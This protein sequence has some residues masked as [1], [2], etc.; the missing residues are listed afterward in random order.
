MKGSAASSDTAETIDTGEV[1]G[2][3]TFFQAVMNVLN[4]LTGVGLLSI[5]FAL[6]QAG[7]AG[8]GILWLLGIVTNYTGKALVECHDVVLQRAKAESGNGA[9]PPMIGYEDI[10]GAAFGA[11]GH[12]IVSSVMYVE[13]LGTCAL[14]FILEGDNLFQLLGT[15]LAGSSGGYMVLAALVMVPTVWLPDLKSLSYLGFAGITATSTVTAAV[16]Y[17]L[18]TGGFPAG[19]VTSVGNWATMPLVFGIMAFVYSG[20][21]VFPSVRASMKRPEQFPKV[22]DVAYLVVGGLCTFIGAAGYYMYGNAALDVITFNLPKGLLAT[23]CASLILVN[24]VAKFA[25]TLDPVAVA[26]N[27]SLATVTPGAPAGVRRFAV[28]TL[29][30]AGC[31]A[32]ARFVPFL[33]YVMS[34]IGSFLTISVSVIFPAA[35]HLSIFRGKL[36]RRR[37]LWNYAVVGIGVV[38]ALSGTAASLRALLQSTATA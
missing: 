30:A 38:C 23:L 3:A 19:A 10:G 32:A 22:L 7:W 8:L 35:C 33:A 5:P 18:L 16:A 21:G 13:L 34:L 29:M 24:P 15:K 31:L 9:A 17:T 1:L 26:A 36:S 28:R 4:I 37:L 27:T 11:I 6:R 20:H 12:T 14:L 2:N 25:I